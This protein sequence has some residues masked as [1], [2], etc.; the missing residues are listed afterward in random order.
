MGPNDA[1]MGRIMDDRAGRE[2]NKWVP[3]ANKAQASA[4]IKKVSSAYSGNAQADNLVNRIEKEALGSFQDLFRNGVD[5]SED[6]SRPLLQSLVILSDGGD[7]TAGGV[8]AGMSA[9]IAHEK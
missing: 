2:K 8:T 3:A 6:G 7:T 4:L 1:G 9:K 5:G